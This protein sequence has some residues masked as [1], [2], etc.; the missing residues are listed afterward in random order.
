MN[1][2]KIVNFFKN[3]PRI[4]K[5]NIT[6]HGSYKNVDVANPLEKAIVVLN[7]T[8]INGSTL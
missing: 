1:S 8:S 6:L 4:I 7:I 3:D 5:S 2:S